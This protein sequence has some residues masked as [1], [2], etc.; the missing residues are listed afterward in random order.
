MDFNEID[1]EAKESDDISEKID[2]NKVEDSKSGKNKKHKFVVFGL[3]FI[4]IIA[5]FA[6]LCALPSSVVHKGD[7]LSDDQAQLREVQIMNI[8]EASATILDV[9]SDTRSP[10]IP[11]TADFDPSNLDENGNPVSATQ[12]ESV[13]IAGTKITLRT[14]VSVPD[15]EKLNEIDLTENSMLSI[16]LKEQEFI[17][18]LDLYT[19]IENGTLDDLITDTKVQ[20]TV[21]EPLLSETDTYYVRY[22]TIL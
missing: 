18:E 11:T 16:P 3:V 12:T 19:R 9:V 17:L 6:V 8:K 5:V 22:I 13:G 2:E 1:D 14:L 4:I 20:F 21:D 7:A 15:Q 10:I